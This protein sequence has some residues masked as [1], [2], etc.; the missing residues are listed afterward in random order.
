LSQT[1]TVEWFRRFKNG[2]TST[3]GIWA[4]WLTFKICI[5]DCTGEKHYPWK[6]STYWLRSCRRGS[7]YIGSC[8]TV[9]TEDLGMHWIPAKF[10]PRLLTDDLRNQMIMK[11]FWKMSLSVMRCGFMVVMLKP[12]NNPH[13][14]RVLLYLAPIEHNGCAHKWKQCCLFFGQGIMHY[15]FAPEGQTRF[16]SWCPET[17]AGCRTKKATW[18]V[19]CGKLAP[20]TR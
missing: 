12:N 7:I 15:E 19:D 17:S 1:T 2:Q 5:S 18:N 13:T 10:V 6:S 11:I 8:H 20:P 4:V 3:D 16:L 14:G 9:L